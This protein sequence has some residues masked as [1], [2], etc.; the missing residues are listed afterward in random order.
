VIPSVK[1]DLR[2][3]FNTIYQNNLPDMIKRYFTDVYLFCLH[4]DPNDHFKLHPLGI[5]TVIQPIIAT[6]VA[7]SLKSKYVLHLLPYNYAVSVLDGTSFIIKAIQLAIKKF[8][9][10]PQQAHHPPTLAA[11][12]LT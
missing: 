8:I 1:P 10:A 12:S 4:K 3:I 11:V 2:F 7:R 6:H 5:P 9:D